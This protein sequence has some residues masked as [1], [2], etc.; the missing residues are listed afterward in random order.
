MPCLVREQGKGSGQAR[1]VR[2]A[3]RMHEDTLLYNDFPTWSLGNM[4]TC[5]LMEVPERRRGPGLS[6]G[7]GQAPG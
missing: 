5:T 7:E 3:A 2:H 1:K 6:R 4:D